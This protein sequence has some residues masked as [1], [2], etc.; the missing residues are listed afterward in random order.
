[1]FGPDTELI[2]GAMQ[3]AAIVAGITG[4]A[5]YLLMSRRKSVR[6]RDAVDRASKLDLEQRVQVLERIATDRSLDL[7]DEIE[8]LRSTSSQPTKTLE[9]QE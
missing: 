5:V 4:A 1:M 8:A 7:A 2:F 3:M 6:N 9:G